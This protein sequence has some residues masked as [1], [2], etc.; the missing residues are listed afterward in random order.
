MERFIGLDAHSSSSVFAVMGPSG[1]KLRSDDVETNARSLVEYLKLVPG[2]LHLCTEEGSL[3][4]W[5]H[6]VLSPHVDKMVVVGV[7]KRPGPKSDKID[8]FRLAEMCRAGSFDAVVYKGV[9][10]YGRLR[11][12]CKTHQQLVQDSV[13]V[14]NRIKFRFRSRGVTLGSKKNVFRQVEREE[15][16]QRLPVGIRCGCSMLFAEYDALHDIRQKA[17]K[18]LHAELRKHSI[19]RTLKSCPGMGPIRIARLLSVVVTPHRFRTK[20]QFWSYC[21]LAIVTH[22][23]HEKRRVNGRWIRVAEPR[24]RG[25]NY[26]HNHTLKDVFKG[27]ALSAVTAHCPLRVKYESLCDNGTKPHLARLTIARKIAAT[28]LAM[29]KHKEV[30]DSTRQD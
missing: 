26:N 1:R 11:E 15:W 29:W 23:S 3:S 22:V 21:G 16:M 2:Q 8:A 18:A 24:P 6:E 28:V 17:E 5:L 30:Y 19:A 13:R 10:P 25:L 12:L 9:G 14:Q 20:R 4:D 7:R 27:A